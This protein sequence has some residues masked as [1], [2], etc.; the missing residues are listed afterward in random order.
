MVDALTIH[1]LEHPDLPQERVRELLVELFVSV[2]AAA[3]TVGAR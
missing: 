3:A 2:V 1:W